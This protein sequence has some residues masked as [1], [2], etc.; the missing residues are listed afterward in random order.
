MKIILTKVP[1]G[2]HNQIDITIEGEFGITTADMAIIGK[3][4]KLVDEY[5]QDQNNAA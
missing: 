5:N 2:V 1:T 3:V 4:I